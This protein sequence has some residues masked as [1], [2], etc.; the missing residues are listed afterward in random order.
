MKCEKCDEPMIEKSW[1]SG[2]DIAIL[3]KCLECGYEVWYGV[4][5]F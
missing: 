4:G 1:S 2:E 5:L 3:S